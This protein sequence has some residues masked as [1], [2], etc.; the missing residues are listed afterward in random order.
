MNNWKDKNVLVLGA[1]RQGLS[2]TRYLVG[3]GAHVTLNDQRPSEELSPALEGLVGLPVEWV[4]GGHP[5]KLLGDIDLVCVSGGVP[6]TLPIIKE[7]LERGIPLSNDL[8]VF[9]EA[10]PCPVVGITGS[11]GKTT[12]TTLVGRI[13]R[14]AYSPG[15]SPRVWVGGNIGFPL[16]TV[17][18][19]IKPRDLVILELSSF[20]L[21]LM[22]RSPW[23]AAVL[24][25]T[26]NHLDRHRSMEAYT[27][28]K[29]GI[30]SFQTPQDLAVLGREDPGAWSM[31]QR[32]TGRLVS[33][34]IQ[35]PT[36]GEDATSVQEGMLCLHSS[37]QVVPL[38]PKSNILLRGDH[39]LQNVLAACAIAYA[40]GLP[41]SAMQ[42]GIEGFT[43]VPHR[44]Q[45][46]L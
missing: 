2:L 32:V 12:V 24:N 43:G 15:Q 22:T 11:A 7:A 46:I 28:A 23:V 29:A 1:A 33:F 26:P 18:D 34:G 31:A 39:N 45:W 6:L 30:L 36:G 3:Q 35:S 37:G 10:V 25:I 5:L 19:Q 41:A 27:A 16:I 38:M 21:E 4:L 17:V 8:Q 9:M 20:Q 14:A 40:A 42:T 13:A 44:L